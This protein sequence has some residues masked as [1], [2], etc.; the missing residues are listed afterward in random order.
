MDLWGYCLPINPTYD[1]IFQVQISLVWGK[2]HQD[3]CKNQEVDAK[4]DHFFQVKV[5]ATFEQMNQTLL[6]LQ[7]NMDQSVQ[8][9]DHHLLQAKRYF[10]EDYYSFLSCFSSLKNIDHTYP[11]VR[12]MSNVTYKPIEWDI[13]NEISPLCLLILHL[14][15]FEQITTRTVCHLVDTTYDL[16]V[17]IYT[18]LPWSQGSIFSPNCGL[19]YS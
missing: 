3:I 17:C 14:F 1:T 10:R 19:L 6:S 13:G 12:M 7:I 9:R 4:S 11:S 16:L 15:F 2:R 18:C 5:F 8:M